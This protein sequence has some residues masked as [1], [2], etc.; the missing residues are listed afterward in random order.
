M[1]I[2]SHV[3]H[4]RDFGE[5]VE[6]FLS[7]IGVAGVIEVR[8]VHTDEHTESQTPVFAPMGGWLA[9][10]RMGVA[11]ARGEGED[12][13]PGARV[14]AGVVGEAARDRGAR[15]LQFLGDDLLVDRGHNEGRQCPGWASRRADEEGG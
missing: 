4:P 3:V 7:R 13:G 1:Q 12:L 2:E 6:Q 14:D 8:Q 5:P 9:F 11:H 10:L 15:E